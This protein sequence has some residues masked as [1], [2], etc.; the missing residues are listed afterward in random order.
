MASE[1]AILE[2]VAR[3]LFRDAAAAIDSGNIDTTFIRVARAE[4]EIDIGSPLQARAAAETLLTQRLSHTEKSSCWDIVG[5]VSLTTGQIERGLKALHQASAAAVLSNDRRLQA[6]LIASNCAALLNWIGIEPAAAE[7]PQLRKAAISIGDPYCLVSY[8]SILA[9]IRAKKGLIESA[10]RSVDTASG[11]LK[12]WPNVWQQGRLAITSTAISILES[13]YECALVST[14]EALSCAEQSGSRRIRVPALGNFAHIKLAQGELVEAHKAINQCLA[15]VQKGGNTEIGL[16][17]TELQI[18]LAGRDLGLAGVLAPRLMATSTLLENGRSYCGLWFLLTRVKWMYQTGEVAAGLALALDSIPEIQRMADSNL[19]DRMKLLAA[20]GL[21]RQGRTTEGA[22]VLAEVMSARSDMPLEVG[23]ESMRVSGRLTAAADPAAARGHFERAARAFQSVGNVTA[24]EEVLQDCEQTLHV[25]IATLHA[26]QVGA[27]IE[28]LG[29]GRPASARL[30]EH[31]AALLDVAIIPPL[32]ATELLALIAGT[33]SARQAT[34]VASGTNRRREL[35]ESYSGPQSRSAIDDHPDAIRLALGEHHGRQYEIVV[36]PHPSAPARTTLLAIQRL[37]N[38]A[39]SLSRA[40]VLERERADLWPEQTP[41]QQLGLICASERT[42]ELVKTVRQVAGS[43]V[44]VLLAGETGVGKELF[45]RALHQASIRSDR[46][47]LPFNCSTVPR[48][49]IDSQLFGHRRGS[50][51]GALADAPGIIRSA[52][53]GTLFLDEIGEM[54]IEVQPKLLRFLESGEILPLGQTKPEVVDVRIVAAT[55]ANL[56]QAVADGRFREDLFY[57]LNVIRINIPPLR[58]RREEIPALVDYFLEKF[59]RE[60]QKPMLRV[61]DET[62]EYLVLYRWP[63]NVRQLANELRRMVAMAEPGAVLMP[64]HL[65][66][67][68]AA[69]RRTVPVD[70]SPRVFSEVVTRIDQPL[71]AAVE[72]IER[73]A[74]Q[75]ALSMSDGRLDEAAKMLGLSRKGL[76]LKRQRLDLG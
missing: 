48:D 43:N 3:G 24:R 27:Q 35:L 67:D 72:H 29:D 50:F 53:G 49:M 68:I 44:T 61:A 58:E 22:R 38:T 4:L 59:G 60:L 54:A 11:L 28:Q 65:S 76:Y 33:G 51:T 62:L 23:A 20:D 26:G 63:G 5:R 12:R 32:L 16:L 9:Q 18:A 34:V 52:A 70:A 36:L 56:D 39:L 64:A 21:G 73:A 10:K 30:V 8:H 25:S 40:R 71:S 1:A 47:F 45:A 6:R 37:V 2:L 75:R 31:V 57:R 13:D 46:V 69:S 15:D 55:N 7:L 74:I 42:L 41:E 19:L 66:D 17:D 14:K